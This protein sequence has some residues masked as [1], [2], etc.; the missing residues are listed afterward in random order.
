MSYCL[1]ALYCIKTRV[2]ILY[3]ELA[4]V[5]PLLFEILD[6][7]GSAVRFMCFTRS[8]ILSLRSDYVAIRSPTSVSQLVLLCIH[9]V[10]I[11]HVL[12]WQVAIADFI[13]RDIGWKFS[14]RVCDLVIANA[15]A[16]RMPWSFQPC[17]TFYFTMVVP[18]FYYT[19][20]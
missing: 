2:W 11:H 13:L 7:N 18:T 5:W 3:V 10:L 20:D 19:S 1:L 15:S 16:S 6:S 8:N 12:G 17:F 9:Y 14:H 4:C